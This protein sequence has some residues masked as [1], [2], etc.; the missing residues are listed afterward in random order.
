[1][2]KKTEIAIEKYEAG[3][4]KEALRLASEFRLGITEEERKQMKLGYEC[5]VHDDFYKQMGK[6]P[7]AEISK[8]VHVFLF[9]IY[10]P[11]KERTA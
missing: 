5:M 6:H 7:M 2:K 11:Y 4:I 3:H 1:M 10:L 9:K 8:A